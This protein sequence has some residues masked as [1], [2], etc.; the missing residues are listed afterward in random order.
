MSC[1]PAFSPAN[2]AIRSHVHWL[3]R[4]IKAGLSTRP[5]HFEHIAKARLSE[6]MQ[7]PEHYCT[8]RRPQR[9]QLPRSQGPMLLSI[10][11]VERHVER[12][13]RKQECNAEAIERLKP[14]ESSLAKKCLPGCA[15]SSSHV[16]SARE[17]E[18]HHV[19]TRPATHQA[20]L[21]LWSLWKLFGARCSSLAHW[22]AGVLVLMA[23]WHGPK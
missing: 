16:K 7:E 10:W 18:D 3:R 21:V 5:L 17:T 2:D 4:W 23:C 12:H 1:Y 19:T 13:A 11:H 22:P 20:P 9:T 6:G 15:A 8:L 14:R